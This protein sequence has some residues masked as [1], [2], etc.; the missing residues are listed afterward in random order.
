MELGSVWRLVACSGYP[1]IMKWFSLSIGGDRMDLTDTTGA[2]SRR[3]YQGFYDC[4]PVQ[5]S[6]AFIGSGSGIYSFEADG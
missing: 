4:M 3:I 1:T 5:S 6:T 2:V